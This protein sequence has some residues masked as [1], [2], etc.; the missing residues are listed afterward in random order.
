MKII[1]ANLIKLHLDI[2]ILKVV[3]YNNKNNIETC[4][5]GPQDTF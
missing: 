2:D 3:L 1:H 5:K 4:G